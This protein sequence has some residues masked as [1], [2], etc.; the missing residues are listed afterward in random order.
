MRGGAA[1]TLIGLAFVAIALARPDPGLPAVL[2]G[3]GLNLLIVG[4][5]FVL[6]PLIGRLRGRLPPW[7]PW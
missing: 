2:G 3:L 6:R 7:L 1:L 5:F 4:V